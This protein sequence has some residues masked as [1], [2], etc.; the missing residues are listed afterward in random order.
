MEKLTGRGSH[1]EFRIVLKRQ[2]WAEIQAPIEHVTAKVMYIQ[3]ESCF[4]HLKNISIFLS[5]VAVF[6]SLKMIALVHRVVT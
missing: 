1:L 3:F 5:F 2:I 6:T 4:F